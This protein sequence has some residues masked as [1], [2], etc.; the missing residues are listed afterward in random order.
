[1]IDNTSKEPT[2]A[3]T[4][5]EQFERHARFA[6]MADRA[7]ADYYRNLLGAVFF[8]RLYNTWIRL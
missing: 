2:F 3:L 1:M 7:A 8:R 5:R 4:T 6:A